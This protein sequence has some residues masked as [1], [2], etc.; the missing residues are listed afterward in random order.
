MTNVGFILTR[1]AT[2][3]GRKSQGVRSIMAHGTRLAAAVTCCLF[4]GRAAADSAGFFWKEPSS[5]DFN[6]ASSWSTNDEELAVPGDEE[7]TAKV[8]PRPGDSITFPEGE[9]TVR[10]EGA[11]DFVFTRFS[12]VKDGEFAVTLQ[13]GGYTTGNLDLPGKGTV[14]F[15]DGQVTVP[16][17]VPGGSF[18]ILDGV[19]MT[20]A[21]IPQ[22]A[23][24]VG[25]DP[26][27]AE[28]NLYNSSLTTQ[29]RVNLHFVLLRENSTWAHTGPA[30]AFGKSNLG[31]AARPSIFLTG[32]SV[33][34]AA[35][36][37]G[38][39]IVA[40]NEGSRVEVGDFVGEVVYA[41]AGGRIINTNAQAGSTPLPDGFS[42]TEITG[43][44]SRWEVGGTLAVNPAA[45][46]YVRDG[47]RLSA[48]T[49]EFDAR[50]TGGV[51]VEHSG[52]RL[53]VHQALAMPRGSSIRLR[54][55]ASGELPAAT[56]DGGS[57]EAGGSGAA[58]SFEGLVEIKNANSQVGVFGGGSATAPELHV[59][60]G[61]AFVSDAGSVIMAAGN[62]AAGVGGEGAVSVTQGGR[63]DSGQGTIGWKD[64]GQGTVNV[65][66]A[67]SYWS[68]R[69][70]LTVGT[71]APSTGFLNVM[72]GGRVDLATEGAPGA[73]IALAASS[74]GTVAV[75]GAGSAV[76]ARP[77][78]I[79]GVGVGGAGIL[80]VSAGGRF[81]CSRLEAGV[82]AGSSGSVFLFGN[83]ASLE[84]GDH[85][86]LIGSLGRGVLSLRNGGQVSA[87]EVE[88]GNAAADNQL[89]VDGNG[90][91]LTVSGGGVIVGNKGAATGEVKNGGVIAAPRGLILGA[92]AAGAG[93][94][95]V[96]GAGSAVRSPGGAVAAGLYGS[97]T[98][99]LEA[100]ATVEAARIFVGTRTD[101]SGLMTITGEGSRLAATQDVTIGEI[102]NTGGAAS[103]RLT[104]AESALVTSP[105]LA[106]LRGGVAH[107]A[108]GRIALGAVAQPPPPGVL[109][110][111]AG[112]G[113]FLAGTFSGGK[114]VVDANGR[115][116]PGASPGTATVEGEVEFLPGSALVM[117]IA[118]G[119]AGESYDVIEAGGAVTLGGE[120]VL[121]FLDGYAPAAGDTY[122][123]VRSPAA[124]RTGQFQSVRVVG[125][126]PGFQHELTVDAAGHLLLRALNAGVSAP[127][128][129]PPALDIASTG[130]GIVVTWETTPDAAWMLE[131]ATDPGGFPWAP[132]PEARSPLLVPPD[133]PAAFFRLRFQP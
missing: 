3:S 91:A 127:P 34:T 10:M 66:G 72:E 90:A 62:L 70:D 126:N 110:I 30:D 16:R 97:G 129:P 4:P 121:H 46:I 35:A 74:Q 48:G 131:T 61:Q 84:A 100:G 87:G 79:M 49:L 63:L 23:A 65:T 12:A 83:G 77:V 47:G 32:S 67:G 94:M 56:L 52:S 116:V 108:G 2:A 7:M 1:F 68:I 112:G 11:A 28:L 114:I 22:G 44:G 92:E 80:N 43:T 106:V 45:V 6:T 58:L 69:G 31:V 54:D 109:R 27:D 15:E 21:D 117:E 51:V 40:A 38:I 76:D 75:A 53:E 64:G 86:L 105:G 8:P 71:L 120:L 132:L 81:L 59:G 57:L 98:L 124:T 60:S 18:I 36:T 113:L 89:I 24:M 107:L 115:F 102:G 96:S 13:G 33:F 111:G 118:G 103:A 82:Q 130:D 20:I 88:I 119:V 19:T 29:G 85:G 125:L 95:T 39:P 123:L 73:A 50:T 128:P 5:G 42:T 26:R 14:W 104:V 9:Y 122:E 101:G 37:E 55:G 41:S 93:V 99:T 133:S 78:G 17:F 25:A